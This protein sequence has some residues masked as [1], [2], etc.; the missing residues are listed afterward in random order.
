MLR[1]QKIQKSV[2]V[3]GCVWNGRLQVGSSV[4]LRQF[5]DMQLCIVEYV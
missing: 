1:M 2:A 4:A 5:I 3:G